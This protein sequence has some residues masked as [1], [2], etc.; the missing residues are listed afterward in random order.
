MNEASPPSALPV[1]RRWRLQ[2]GT[3]TLF[4]IVVATA[5]GAWYIG[6]EV[7][8]EQRRE[9]LIAAI[10]ARRGY[11][12]AKAG[13]PWRRRLAAWLRGKHRTPMVDSADLHA[14]LDLPLMREFEEVYPDAGLG[15]EIAGTPSP[16]VQESLLRLK[17]LR[18]IYV[19]GPIDPSDQSL[20]WLTKLQRAKLLRLT[21]SVMGESSDLYRHSS[22]ADP[23]LY[24]DIA[25]SQT[26]H[27][28]LWNRASRGN[29]Y[30][31]V[32]AELVGPEYTDASADAL[33]TLPNLCVLRLT[34]TKLTDAGIAK[35]IGN[36]NLE[37]L[38]L[39]HEQVGHQTI[40]AI[41]CMPGLEGI[42]LQ[43]IPLSPELV[44]ALAKHRIKSLS[45]DG[46]Y[47]DD[48]IK[49][50]APLAPSLE[51]IRLQTP[52][53]TDR[54]VD[55][56]PDA[57]NL[58]GLQLFDTQV[59][60]A[61]I[62]RIVT[63][64]SELHIQLSGPDAAKVIPPKANR[65]FKL[66]SLTLLGPAID[67]Q[68]L[69]ALQPPY[70]YLDLIGTRVTAEGLKS[71]KT[72]GRSATVLMTGTADSL[73]M[74]RGAETFPIKMA[75]MGRTQV[76]FQPV[77]PAVLERVLSRILDKTSAEKTSP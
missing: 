38:G 65:P 54:G 76:W 72:E 3:R 1:K 14:T 50:L 69:A 55:W 21:N 58:Q 62:E 31:L 15:L 59:T 42:E 2:F 30:S 7:A 19:S 33:A 29:S 28:P 74:P 77:E 46:D 20:A 57:H 27:R 60:A 16:E 9:A 32:S 5:F 53:V 67:D 36:Q 26:P 56:L 47:P 22:L 64:R 13:T 25:R 49:L 71:L 73:P 48:Q 63:N 66:G 51:R 61:A 70:D 35:A 4:L 37:L 12:Q 68:V 44:A 10:F 39:H 75:E 11:V 17:T 8:K 40:A 41:A 34:R 6:D 24:A 18:E 45:I 23:Y 43:G 52:N